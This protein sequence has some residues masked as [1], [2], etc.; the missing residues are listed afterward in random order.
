MCYWLSGLYFQIFNLIE[1]IS[2]YPT[3]IGLL[4][5]NLNEQKKQTNLQILTK[6]KFILALKYKIHYKFIGLIITIVSTFIK[7]EKP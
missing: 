5:F 1:C 3:F 2:D 7:D 4:Y 6:I